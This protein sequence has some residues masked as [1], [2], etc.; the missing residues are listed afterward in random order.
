M[1]EF[2]KT[3]TFLLSLVVCAAFA[4]QRK[5]TAP[6]AAPS[7]TVTAAQP[8]KPPTANANTAATPDAAVN[9]NANV[10]AMKIIRN[11]NG[12]RFSNSKPSKAPMSDMP[13]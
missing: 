10:S 11:D 8:A 12:N 5:K 13:R 6:P 7:S 3:L 4:C 9:A 1:P 2:S